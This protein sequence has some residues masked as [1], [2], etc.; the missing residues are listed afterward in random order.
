MRVI[1]G[2]ASGTTQRALARNLNG[3]RGPLA[4]ENLAPCANNFRCLHSSPRSV[5]AQSAHTMRGKMPPESGKH[6]SAN[7]FSEKWSPLGLTLSA[8]KHRDLA[9]T[10]G[11][12]DGA[13]FRV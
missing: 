10:S 6:A 13:D 12:R 9:L 11:N 4:R 5:Q 8:R 2:I 3:K 1:I 7:W